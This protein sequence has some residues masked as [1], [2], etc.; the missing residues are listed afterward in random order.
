MPFT[1]PTLTQALATLSQRLTDPLF[2]RWTQAELTLYLQEA[3]QTW[4]CWTATYR[5]RG[6][7]PL[8]I[9]QTFYDLPTELPT[10]R[11]STVTNWQ[12][13]TAIEYH[14]IEPPTPGTWTGS[15]Q[16]DLVRITQALE[17][18][19]DRFLEE[20][21]CQVNVSLV[22]YA[23]NATGRFDL[24][25]TIQVI[26]RIDWRN[27]TTQIK[28]PLRKTDEFA[29]RAFLPNWNVPATQP[30]YFSTSAT[31]PLTLQVMPPPLNDG[32]ATLIT[33]N[34]GA[35]IDP[36]TEAALG[37]PNDWAWVV[38][39][40]ALSDLWS[41]EGLSLDP[42]RAEYAEQRWI[43]GVTLAKSQATVLTLQING[44]TRQL[45][46]MAAA[47]AYSP[48]WSLITGVPTRGV[49]AG[50]SLFAA[51]PPPGGGGTY[52]ATVDVVTT[53]PI[54]TVGGSI[55]Q[56][57]QPQYDA[58]LDYAQHLAM[59]KEGPGQLDIATSLLKRAYTTANIDASLQQAA[60]P[61]RRPLLSQSQGDDF[62]D[63][64]AEVVIPVRPAT[65]G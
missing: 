18:R 53:A 4:N 56:V 16:F 27:Q 42:Q 49:T 1:Q 37:I 47:D 8:I 11:P 13:V 61:A 21:G 20:T 57:T 45:A 35:A 48:T 2:V 25:E 51:W 12:V 41:Q 30:R 9:A 5:G 55:L 3:L 24:D 64:Q 50:M 34:R 44:A 46:S 62:A 26:R 23:A 29:A 36:G 6:T 32:T 60:Q 40:G 38:K 54:P 63:P 22:D 14:L 17:R 43:E 15:D 59:V 33:T 7:F 58:I 52:E 10:L 65:G 19:R 39:W 28:I 31:P